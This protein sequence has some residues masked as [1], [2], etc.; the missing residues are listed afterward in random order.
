MFP[1]GRQHIG[2]IVTDREE[3]RFYPS[4]ATASRHPYKRHGLDIGGSRVGAGY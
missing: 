4:K 3:T 1:N 2:E